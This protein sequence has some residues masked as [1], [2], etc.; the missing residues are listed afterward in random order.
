METGGRIARAM[1]DCSTDLRLY[2][3]KIKV[4]M[5]YIDSQT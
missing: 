3:S 2:S 1:E 4:Q 5:N